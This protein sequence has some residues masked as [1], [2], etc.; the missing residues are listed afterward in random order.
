MRVDRRELV[1]A[2]QPVVQ[3]RTARVVGQHP[4]DVLLNAQTFSVCSPLQLVVCV[5]VDVSDEK[6]GHDASGPG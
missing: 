4:N 3:Q 1:E 6:V 2:T 5:P